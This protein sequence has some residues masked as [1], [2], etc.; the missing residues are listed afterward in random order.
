MILPQKNL[1]KSFVQENNVQQDSAKI[2]LQNFQIIITKSKW[3]LSE[4]KPR[5]DHGP[6]LHC[7]LNAWSETLILKGL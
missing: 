5:H 7:S 4:C 2:Y 1:I 3:E 6:N